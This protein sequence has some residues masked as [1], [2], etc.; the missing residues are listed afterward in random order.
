MKKKMVAD[1]P[2]ALAEREI[3]RGVADADTDTTLHSAA[4]ATRLMARAFVG[5]LLLL[6]PAAPFMDKSRAGFYVRIPDSGAPRWVI[7]ERRTR[8]APSPARPGLA[9]VASLSCASRASQ[10]CVGGGVG[11]G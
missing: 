2:H 10:T 7:S 11:R 3:A 6:P 9:R 4:P 8:S 5:H 1:I